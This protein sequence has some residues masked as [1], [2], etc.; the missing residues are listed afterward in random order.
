MKTQKGL[1]T[2]ASMACGLVLMLTA[3]GGK[4]QTDETTGTVAVVKQP[5]IIETNQLNPGVRDTEDR[6]VDPSR[7]PV[8]LD[9]TQKLPATTLSL[10]DHYTNASCVTLRHPLP[11]NEGGFLYDASIAVYYDQGMSSGSGISTNVQ[12]NDEYIL[13]SDLFGALIFDQ[14]GNLI[15]STALTPI[16]EVKYD[17]KEQKIEYNAKNR[18]ALKSGLALENGNI[19]RYLERDT[20]RDIMKMCWK[21][22][23]DGTI[24]EE[25]CFVE[26]PHTAYLMSIDDSTLLAESG[27]FRSPT[28]FVTFNKSNYDT[29]C[30]F[31]NYNLPTVKLTGPYAFPERN[32]L[33][34]LNDRCYYRQA[35]CDTV[36]S[37]AAANKIEPAYIIQFGDKRTD[38]N[39]GLIG[40]KAQK[41][42]A[43]KWLDTDKFILF[44]YSQNYDCPN[45]RNSNSVF[46]HY[47]LY[48]KTK[49]QLFSLPGDNTYPE[50]YLV[51][52]DVPNGIPLILNE[53]TIQDN[54]LVSSY[55]KRKLEAMQK[56]KAFS[57]LPA[58]Q[59]DRVKEL[60]GSLADN[61]MIVMTLE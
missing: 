58:A 49:K 3:C 52:A 28:L 19:Y 21:D 54:K 31:N 36:F 59:Q 60:A 9:F 23:Q 44:I 16:K 51:P 47:A 5:V 35:F 13:T 6:A 22:I 53:V 30:V 4:K 34:K 27:N 29:L 10:K 37:I 48:D 40:D 39:T 57:Q 1:T 45:T 11:A 26:K 12:V 56:M 25:I 15:D 8:V 2:T 55:T 20:V 14:S 17:S 41:M 43:S 32:W 46:Y 7:P 18:I 33:Y 61:E 38:I 50:E 42:I 24:A